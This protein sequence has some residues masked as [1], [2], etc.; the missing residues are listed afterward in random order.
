VRPIRRA[1][2]SSVI[3]YCSAISSSSS[4]SRS[5]TWKLPLSRRRRRLPSSRSQ[6]VVAS[7]SP[8][9]TVALFLLVCVFC[10]VFASPLPLALPVVAPAVRYLPL[11]TM[12]YAER[13]RSR[14]R[15]RRR[16]ERERRQTSWA[17]GSGDAGFCDRVG[18]RQGSCSLAT[19]RTAATPLAATRVAMALAD[20]QTTLVEMPR[21]R[22]DGARS[23]PKKA[24]LIQ[25]KGRNGRF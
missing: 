9:Q 17:S 1:S 10:C 18:N 13:G 4:R 11:S 20:V 24:P 15:R 21:R 12:L 14:T 16:R 7:A 19:A 3:A 5:E 6:V 8:P 22:R 25:D 2:W 23:W